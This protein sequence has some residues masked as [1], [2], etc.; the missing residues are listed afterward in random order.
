[1]A[2]ELTKRFQGTPAAKQAGAYSWRCHQNA[3]ATI[4]RCLHIEHAISNLFA[5]HLQASRHVTITAN[6][7]THVSARI[8]N[9]SIREGWRQALFS[10]ERERAN[11]GE[12]RPC[13]E[14]WQE[15]F[16][17][18][19][20]Q[21]ESNVIR[22]TPKH[23]RPQISYDEWDGLLRIAFVRKN[24]VMRSNFFGNEQCDGYVGGEL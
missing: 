13:D 4:L 16:Q 12:S 23:P 11:V 22:L 19:P 8:C 18:P 21:V 6:M 15:Q 3:T 10:S 9:A 5:S 14:S 20:P 2:A 17:H 24:R 7:H 1:M